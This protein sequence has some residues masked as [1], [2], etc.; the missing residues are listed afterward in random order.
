[1]GALGAE[2]GVAVTLGV[3][4]TEGVSLIE[5]TTASSSDSVESP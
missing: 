4:E 5:I 2:E 3:A 1:M